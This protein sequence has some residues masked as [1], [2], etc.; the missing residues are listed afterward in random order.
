MHREQNVCEQEVMTG[1]M[2]KSLQTWHRRAVSMGPSLDTGVPNQSEGSGTS[3]EPSINA[4]VDCKPKCTT[5]SRRKASVD[6]GI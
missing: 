6:V 5:S 3:K 1:V 2:K 4:Q